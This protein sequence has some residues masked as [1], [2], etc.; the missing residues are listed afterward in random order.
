MTKVVLNIVGYN[1][2]VLDLNNH[3]DLITFYHLFIEASRFAYSVRSRFGDVDYVPEALGEA[4]TVT[5]QE[6]GEYV[7]N[8]IFD[9]SQKVEY[10]GM[11]NFAKFDHGT[12][13]ISVVDAEG[14]AVSL[15]STI[16]F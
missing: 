16:N 7:R 14:N 15:T 10:Y 6:F 3:R 9:T 12:A 4:S 1:F 11:Q 8:R 5:S 2:K 13:H